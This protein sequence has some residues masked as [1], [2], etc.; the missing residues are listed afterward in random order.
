MNLKVQTKNMICLFA[1]AA[2]SLQLELVYVRICDVLFNQSIGYFIMTIALVVFFLAG[3]LVKIYETRFQHLN[4]ES[5]LLCGSAFVIS[6]VMTIPILRLLS[7]NVPLESLINAISRNFISYILIALPFLFSG[8]AL[9][10]LFSMEQ[11]QL[12]SSYM[13]DILGGATGAFIPY[14]LIPV[15]GPEKEV[16]LIGLI[17]LVTIYFVLGGPKKKL[18][19]VITLFALI[20]C[21]GSLLFLDTQAP[22]KSF[23]KK[24]MAHDLRPE[25]IEYSAWDINARIDVVDFSNSNE[26][27]GINLNSH[28]IKYVFYDSG[29]IGTNIYPFNGNGPELL[30][31]YHENPK[32]YFLRL[33]TVAA[34]DLKRDSN[35]RAYLFGVGAGQEVKAALIH[36]ASEIYANELVP[37][38]I[39]ISKNQYAEYNGQ[40]F[41]SP[42]VHILLGDGRLQLMRTEGLFDVIQIFSNYLSSSI[43]SG[44]GLFQVTYL[45]TVEAMQEYISKLNSDGILQINQFGYE[46]VLSTLT[47]AWKLA[48]ENPEELKKRII[49]IHDQATS[50]ILTTVLFKKSPF[51]ESELSELKLLFGIGKKQDYIFLESPENSGRAGKILFISPQGKNINKNF[52]DDLDILTLQ[53]PPTDDSPFFASFNDRKLNSQTFAPL[54]ALVTLLILGIVYLIFPHGLKTKFD[55]NHSLKIKGYFIIIGAAYM[56]CQAT[57]V[58]IFLKQLEMPSLNYALVISGL[59]LGAGL[60]NFYASKHHKKVG[61]LISYHLQIAGTAIILFAWFYPKLNHFI[62]VLDPAEIRGLVVFICI[63]I[64]GALTGLAFPYGI[65]QIQIYNRK[66]EKNISIAWIANGLGIII[67][68]LISIFAP[69]YF[70]FTVTLTSVGVLYLIS[71]L[72]AKTKLTD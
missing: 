19:K 67:G 2:A 59:L 55:Q 20:L 56:L 47:E 18:T 26:Q 58:Q 10:K 33:A 72:F 53:S 17:F 9:I 52:T 48:G 40:I 39:N 43:S 50:D 35:Y 30:A 16:A 22:L 45:F 65:A 25:Q 37:T 69:I 4:I 36:G 66:E 42:K 68:S 51:T 8:Y 21:I 46:R 12:H 38:V 27:K 11:A 64:I 7:N 15:L 13:M 5:V 62:T 60:A 34:H 23:T 49:V 32:K 70:G 44:R 31:N 71:S 29:T 41:N 3:A 14:W 61:H 28:E 1:V 57:L 54:I 6:S 24:F 63:S